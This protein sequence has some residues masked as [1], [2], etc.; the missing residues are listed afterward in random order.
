M[1][2]EKLTSTKGGD[3]IVDLSIDPIKAVDVL[4]LT[5]NQ[6]SQRVLAILRQ[7]YSRF[8]LSFE[9]LYGASLN[10]RS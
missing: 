1:I 6:G 7:E 2:D 10:Q 5:R 3:E 8:I 4:A 9:R